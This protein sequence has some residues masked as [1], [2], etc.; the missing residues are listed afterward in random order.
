[1]YSQQLPAPLPPE[2][3]SLLALW[4]V[5]R[6]GDGV[7][8]WRALPLRDLE[9]WFDHI[10][11]IEPFGY[12][13]LRFF[14]FRLCG[15]RLVARFGRD[16]SGLALNDLDAPI[17]NGLRATLERACGTKQPAFAEASAPSELPYCDL[18]L[19]LCDDGHIILLLLASYPL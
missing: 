17:R 19:P 3:Q 18:A 2:L 8:D 6:G 12:G 9:P 4:F 16:V 10:A 7:P 15:A 13:D 1:M 5:R 14:N 11:R